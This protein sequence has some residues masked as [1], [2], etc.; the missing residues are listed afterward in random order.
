MSRGH[1]SEA[2]VFVFIVL[3]SIKMSEGVERRVGQDRTQSVA[4]AAAE[5][6]DG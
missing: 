1:V 4:R 3:M 2:F 5:V 6:I